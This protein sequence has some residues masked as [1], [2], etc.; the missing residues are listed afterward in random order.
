MKKVHLQRLRVE[1][2]TWRRRGF[3]CRLVTLTMV[4]R[5]WLVPHCWGC[6]CSLPFLH[7][8]RTLDRR[9]CL[10]EPQV[11]QASKQGY[12]SHASRLCKTSLSSQ[13]EALMLCLWLSPDG[14]VTSLPAERPEAVL[15]S[16]SSGVPVASLHCQDTG[17]IPGLLQL[18]LGSNPWPRSSRGF[19]AAKKGGKSHQFSKIE[20]AAEPSRLP[21]CISPKH[22][23]LI[24]L[25]LAC[26]KK[27]NRKSK[28]LW[29]RQER[30][31]FFMPWSK[32]LYF[33]SLFFWSF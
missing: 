26:Q 27:K 13:G 20:K 25:F 14:Q 9:H 6:I 19:G 5:Q 1:R 7:E 4:C 11:P 32:F 16:L 21:A 24:N 22:V 18:R 12:G 10:L 23:I 2:G 29:V 28:S 33:F 17:S 8:P 30:L 15:R 31:S 3:P